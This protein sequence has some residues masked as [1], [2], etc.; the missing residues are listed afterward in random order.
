M[1]WVGVAG[2][3]LLLFLCV[4]LRLLV[5][6]LD[7]TDYDPQELKN[8]V[9]IKDVV[10]VKNSLPWKVIEYLDRPSEGWKDHYH[11]NCCSNI[12]IDVRTSHQTQESRLPVIFT[13]WMQTL[14]P[15]K[16]CGSQITKMQPK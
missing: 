12:Y 15:S 7:H 3:I 11:L 6:Q 10:N 1:R 14:P 9:N 8:T 16:V 13:T 2:I 5:L 4:L